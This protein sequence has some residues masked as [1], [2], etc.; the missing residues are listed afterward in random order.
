[1]ADFYL[2]TY[3]QVLAAEVLTYIIPELWLSSEDGV[4]SSGFGHEI[5]VIV[6]DEV[7]VIVFEEFSTFPC[8]SSI[9]T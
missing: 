6:L 8:L 2:A 4:L 5:A 3:A 9:L 7:A 1:V